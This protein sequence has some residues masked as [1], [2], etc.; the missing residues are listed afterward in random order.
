MGRF[1]FT[2][3]LCATAGCAADRTI[4]DNG[5]PGS[6][7]PEV[8]GTPTT[9]T[10]P[11]AQT[12]AVA[13]C[14]ATGFA[15]SAPATSLAM[16]QTGRSAA[17]VFGVRDGQLVGYR[18]EQGVLA[19]DPDGTVLAIGAK[20]VGTATARAGG[21]TVVTT[22]GD[23]AI[24]VDLV[25]PDLRDIRHLTTLSGI[26]VS[27]LPM[28]TAPDG[29]YM[30][31]SID[32]DGVHLDRFDA[33]LRAVG[34]TAITTARRPEG[35]SAAIVGTNSMIAWTANH[36]CHLQFASDVTE[37]DGSFIT[38][39]CPSPHLAVDPRTGDGLIA[40]ASPRGVEVIHAPSEHLT[41]PVVVRGNTSN[42]QV[43][44]DGVRFWLGFVDDHARLVVG[45]FDEQDRFIGSEM[46]G[47][48]G[49]YR[50]QMF[51]EQVVVLSTDSSGYSVQRV[52]TRTL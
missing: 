5:T 15:T 18:F 41:P 40:F 16:T 50:L 11:M 46:G 9:G 22:V 2:L 20:V 13:S 23:G 12:L 1:T 26:G 3:L 6:D 14:G 30:L 28:I 10:M 48:T 47:M 19:S 35:I 36:E 45:F 33:R 49:D 38:E 39:S 52:C 8:M 32:V 51:D 37:S 29:T 34:S 7:P 21:Q 27:D 17:M 31:P 4:V 42:P 44:F 24:S 25:D 43:T